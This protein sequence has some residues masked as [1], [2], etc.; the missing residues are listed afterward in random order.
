[1]NTEITSINLYCP[2]EART[3]SSI[4]LL[5]DKSENCEKIEKYLIFC[6]GEIIGE[7]ADTDYTVCGL[8]ADTTYYFRIQAMEKDSQSEKSNMI[9][10]STKPAPE[11]FNITQYG[12]QG[13]GK[14]LNTQAIQ[15][16][17]DACTEGGMVYIPK[18]VFLTGA[19]FLKGDMTLFIEEGGKLLGSTEI[20]DYPIMNYRFE[21]LETYGYASL[22][23]TADMGNKR[24]KHITIA[25][26]GTIDAS[27]S[28]LRKKELAENL[29]KPG[30]AVCIR[31]TDYVYMKDITVR[32]SPAWCVHTIYCGHVSLNLVKIHTK[33]SE[34]GI[35]YEN[36]VNGDG[37]DP[38]SCH[39]V[40]VFHCTIASEDDCIAIKSG[41]DREGRKIG[42]PSENI[43]ITN[44]RFLSGFGVAVG[45]EMAGGVRN[46]LVQDCVCEDVY[47]AVS[48]KAPRGRGGVVEQV[49][50]DNI[51]QYYSSDEKSDCEWFRGAVYIDQFYSHDVFDL[52]EK[53]PVDESTPVI[54]NIT[55]KNITA[56]TRGGNGLYLAGLPESPLQ[57][58]RL[59]NIRI[60]GRYGM[61][62]NHTENLSM[63]NLS[64]HIC[65]AGI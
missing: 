33:Y 38:D 54:R 45:S 46:I 55:L 41:R 47:S 53:M 9:M 34:D 31:N 4:A 3:H 18:G 59:E 35:P 24:L 11:I 65:P 25:G 51:T 14:T 10:V 50:Y 26:K 19:I 43:R 52:D 32:Q 6:E 16:A 57:N 44:C 37:Y 60:S 7:T 64:V 36:I 39:D 63:K 58:I 20:R 40:H 22:I 2:E 12:A 49:V 23:N 29:G 8:E 48:I 56:G 28:P 61:K 42:I 1:M 13:D 62:I 5:W 27:G 15:K 17:I 30:R 21:G